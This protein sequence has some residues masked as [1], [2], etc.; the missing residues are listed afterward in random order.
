MAEMH[1]LIPLKAM[2]KS[3]KSYLVLLREAQTVISLE[4]LYVVCQV[5]DS[6]GR[7]FPHPCSES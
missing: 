4:C 1:V 2:Y 3:K 7:M 6:N 5:T